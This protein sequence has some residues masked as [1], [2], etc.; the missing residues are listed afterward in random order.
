MLVAINRKCQGRICYGQ[1]RHSQ[2]SRPQDRLHWPPHQRKCAGLTNSRMYARQK[3][4]RHGACQLVVGRT[5]P[6]LCLASAFLAAL[7]LE[8]HRRTRRGQRPKRLPALPEQRVAVGSSCCRHQHSVLA[9]ARAVRP[10]RN[11]T[12]GA[13]DS[14]IDFHSRTFALGEPDLSRLGSRPCLQSAAGRRAP[15]P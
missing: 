7:R 5:E 12:A 13:L 9:G 3:K 1:R 8:R 4:H 11:D 15:V 10:A 2:R 14:L 6:M